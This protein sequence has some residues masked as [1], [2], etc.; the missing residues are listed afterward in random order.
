MTS[1]AEHKAVGEN[2][3]FDERGEFMAAARLE[4]LQDEKGIY[5][6]SI[7]FPS[8]DG[9][10]ALTYILRPDRLDKVPRDITGHSYGSEAALQILP[11]DHFRKSHCI[12]RQLVVFLAEAIRA[13]SGFVGASTRYG[14]EWW[15]DNKADQDK[16]RQRYHG[17]NRMADRIADHMIRKVLEVA[18][19]GALKTAR[20]FP[21][22]Y[23][24]GIY[25]AAATS[26]RAHQ[27][28]EAF[29]YLG[30]LV[31]CGNRDVCRDLRGLSRLA[32]RSST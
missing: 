20:R 18:D 2:A 25:R 31:Y 10:G 32:R 9:A 13:R 29:P 12:E 27:L 5:G 24:Y 22:Q 23:R 26:R 19:Q 6:V 21:F 30:V 3:S 28:I 7:P 15:A 17:L 11:R 14:G 4:Y 16:N 1:N 8:Y